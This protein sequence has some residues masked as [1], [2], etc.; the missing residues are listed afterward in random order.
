MLTVNHCLYCSTVFVPTNA[1]HKYHTAAC[2]KAAYVKGEGI[3]TD[4]TYPL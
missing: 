2:Y 4:N 1:Q 3:E